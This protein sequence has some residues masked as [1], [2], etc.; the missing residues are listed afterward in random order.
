MELIMPLLG[1][2][3][4]VCGRDY[5]WV[6]M[7]LLRLMPCWSRILSFDAGCPIWN[8]RAAILHRFKAPYKPFVVAAAEEDRC[9]GRLQFCLG[10]KVCTGGAETAAETCADAALCVA[11]N[12]PIN[13]VVG[14]P[15]GSVNPGACGPARE[16][17]PCAEIPLLGSVIPSQVN[18]A[19]SGAPSLPSASRPP[20]GAPSEL[21]AHPSP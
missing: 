11:I 12:V 9:S 3:E 20:A 4:D 19:S 2:P 7:L 10:I 15:L 16:L 6:L 14:L 5:N 1:L 13:P 8:V 18:P 21:V 17:C